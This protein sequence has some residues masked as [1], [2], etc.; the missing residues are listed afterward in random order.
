M[1]EEIIEPTVEAEVVE[2]V[3]EE[4]VV[5][6]EK[7]PEQTVVK[8]EEK[9]T[10][11]PGM[12]VVPG[13]AIGSTTIPGKPKKKTEKVVVDE[14]EKVAL[15]STKNVTWYGVGEVKRGYNIVTSKQAA[16]WLRRSHIRIATPEEM[17][18]E[19]EN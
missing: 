17:A 9:T 2:D 16:A 15:Y 18:K 4:A 7:E 3:V 8:L 5:E 12:A 14:E 11:G 13:G 1:S 19:L 6:V 10:S